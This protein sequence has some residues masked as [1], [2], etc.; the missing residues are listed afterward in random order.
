MA[1]R[2]RPAGGWRARAMLLTL[3]AAAGPLCAQEPPSAP[4][5]APQPTTAAREAVAAAPE[6]TG[7]LE[8]VVTRHTLKLPDGDLQYT[9]TAGFLPITGDDDAPLAN[10]FYVAYTLDG[11]GPERPITFAFNGG[12][13]AASLWLHLGMLG[14]WRLVLPDAGTTLPKRIELVPNDATWLPFTDLVFIDPV[15]TGY[16]RPAEGVEMKRFHGVEGDVES[17]GRFIRQ[18]VSRHGR[19]ASPRFL[20]GESYGATR[21]CALAPHLADAYG[22]DLDGL[23]LVSGALDFQT[24]RFTESNDLACVL[25]VPTYAA[26]AW[27]HK[28]LGGELQEDLPRTL[29][30]A[31]RWAHEEYAPALAKGDALEE[32]ERRRIAG[33]L[34]EFTGLSPE[35][36]LRAN[37]RVAHWEF[38]KELLRDRGRIVGILDGRVVGFPREP[39]AGSIAYD[40]ALYMVVGP[41]AS[42]VQEYLR[43]QLGVRTDRRYEPLSGQANRTWEWGS[44]REGFLSVIPRLKGA[45][46]KNPHLRVLAM[47]GLFDVTTG[48]YTQTYALRHLHLPPE[49]RENVVIEH[50]PSGHQIYN[51]LPSLRRA[52]ADARRFYQPPE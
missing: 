30:L 26:V 45:M 52:T 20:A 37:L 47:E 32:E 15:G 50:Y 12:P 1:M 25:Y 35:Y 38:A 19:W 27:Y 5:N 29:R 14:P 36:L 17:V 9:A 41:F 33:T 39:Q 24:F 34:A 18:Y 23:V 22:M 21:A 40:P 43:T 42:A 4:P 7:L 49:L 10:L 46:V 28:R 8:S 51:D 31:E 2:T 48:Y 3:L 11:A 13:G 44:S 6:A 16:S